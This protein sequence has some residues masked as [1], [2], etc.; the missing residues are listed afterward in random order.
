V[1]LVA[2]IYLGRSSPSL[3]SVLHYQTIFGA[4]LLAPMIIITMLEN[5][6]ISGTVAFKGVIVFSLGL[7]PHGFS[8]WILSGSDRL[9]IKSMLGDVQLGYYSLAYTLAMCVMLINSGLGM[10]IP[11][12]IIKHHTVWVNTGKR[13]KLIGMYSLLFLITSISLVVIPH[14]FKEYLPFLKDVNQ[15]VLKLMP[16][17]LN[18]MYFLGIY[19]FYI[20]YLFYKRK[21]MLVSM[22]TTVSAIFSILL[23]FSL[24]RFLGIE[25]AAFSTFFSYLMY[26]GASMWGAIKHDSLPS[27][28][29]RTDIVV[30]T[31]TAVLN[32]LILHFIISL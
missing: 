31:A 11:V 30:I 15:Q 29:Y 21:S 4:L 7:L 9:I 8:Q 16:W 25:G 6:A 10:T 13:T 22:I 26:M 27:N 28:Y 1:A 24:V 32:H 12:D 17:I 14:F 18:G 3:L 5:T 2:A 19:L 23:T 20:N